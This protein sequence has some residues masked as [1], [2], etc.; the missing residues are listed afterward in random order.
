MGF[1]CYTTYHYMRYIGLRGVHLQVYG[2]SL[3]HAY[4]TVIPRLSY[5]C[6]QWEEVQMW[7]HVT[8]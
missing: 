5:P 6:G 3:Y 2:M 8:M 4:C 1:E 7:Q